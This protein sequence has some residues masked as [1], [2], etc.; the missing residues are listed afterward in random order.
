MKPGSVQ[1]SALKTVKFSRQE[2]KAYYLTP[3]QN[4]IDKT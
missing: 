4:P 3:D 2:L 1:K